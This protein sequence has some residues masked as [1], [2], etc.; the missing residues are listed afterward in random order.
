[1]VG[2]VPGGIV[3]GSGS[4]TAMSNWN[5]ATYDNAWKAMAEAGDDPHGEVAFIERALIRHG[6]EPHSP[7]LDAGCGTGRIAIELAAR[8]FEVHGTDVDA[9]ML[10]HARSKAPDLPWHLGNLAYVALPTLFATV[11]M[12]GNVILFVDEPDR[13][14][15]IANVSRYL[16]PGGLLIAGFQLQRGDGRRVP[17]AG[18]DAWTADAGLVLVERFST[19]HDDPFVSGADYAVSV[20]RRT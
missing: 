4:L 8:G 2:C 20:H 10:V 6:H 1:M 15:V 5:P 11:V 18:W 9:S 13:P 12:A 14:E 19:W 7:V 3:T 17:L 16:G